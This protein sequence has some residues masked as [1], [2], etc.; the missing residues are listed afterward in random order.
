MIHLLGIR[1]HGVGSAHNVLAR[2]HQLRPDIILIEGA[3]E[4]DAVISWVGHEELVPPVAVLGYNVDNP[5]QATFYPFA[6]FSPEWQAMCYAREQKIP[7]RMIDAPLFSLATLESEDLQ[8]PMERD[9]LSY[10]AELDGF[11]TTES[12]TWWDYRFEQQYEELNPE[13]YFEAVLLV[14]D[15]LREA[16]LPSALERENVY[17]EAF[18]RQHIRKAHKEMYHTIAIVCG[19]W[20]APALKNALLTEK[21]DNK[22]LKTL[23]KSKVK[24]GVTWIPWA[25]TRLA[26]QS[27]YGAGIYSPG[28]SEYRW[29]YPEDKGQRWLSQVAHCFR[30]KG[31]DVSSAHVLEAYRL[32]EV[33][34]ALRQ[35]AYPTLKEL[36]EAVTTVIC[37]GDI[38]RL[39]IIQKTLIIG[40]RMG[41][42]P[43]SLPRHPIQ[44][45]F[46]QLC[47]K[48][49]LKQQTEKIELE[50]DLRKELDLARSIFLYRLEAMEISWAK[51]T[52]VRG[53]G[54]FKEAWSLQWK[55]EMLI[56]LIERGTWGNT[57]E[58]ATMHFIQHKSDNAINIATLATL[59]QQTIPAELFSLIEG[60]LLKINNLAVISA[61]VID[62]MAAISPLVDVSRYGNVRKTD[63]QAVN[64]LV[65]GLIERICIGLPTI[66]YG[67]DEDV[68]HRIFAHIRNVNEAVRL[69]AQ[70]TLTTQWHQMLTVLLVKETS[71]PLVSGC[72]CRLLLDAKVI[73]SSKAAERLGYMLSRGN[74]SSHA[75]SWLEGFLK[76]SGLI[77]VYDD[78]LWLLINEWLGQLPEA[79]FMELL[80][81]LR[82]TFSKFNS[83]ERQQLGEK[84]RL[85]F[86]ALTTG[87]KKETIK[88]AFDTTQAKLSIKKGLLLLG[89]E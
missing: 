20:H 60:L 37:M 89:L 81:L 79:L 67:I 65:H 73:D 25:N 36:N 76:G 40:E 51:R 50:L 22:I 66:V 3:P 64:Q 21:E 57:V 49:K 46:E 42:V 26:M 61:D 75:A 52:F 35:K 41:V 4:L 14:M 32:S 23:P 15:S 17:R 18:M 83:V 12:G 84:A 1:H 71:P 31:I 62:L 77:L 10:L 56:E 63:F 39:E 24:T 48:N 72:T 27:G 53:K 47:K 38:Q 82:R 29:D 86:E 68:A 88:A 7:V 34:C 6:S 30:Q 5:H 16:Q 43:R 54:T 70:S 69:I 74:E 33:L 78:A 59:I 13:A 28:W 44:N 87:V 55:P 8:S 19:A 9:P 11:S 85:Q 80:P 2:L 45:D 58:L